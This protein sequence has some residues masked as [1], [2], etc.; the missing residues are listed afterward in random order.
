MENTLKLAEAK[1]NLNGRAEKS[2]WEH[3]TTK[4]REIYADDLAGK[5]HF[6]SASVFRTALSLAFLFFTSSLCF[7]QSK[8]CLLDVKE[9]PR[10]GGIQ[11]GMKKA[12]IEAALGTRLDGIESYEFLDLKKEENKFLLNENDSAAKK[13]ID[14]YKPKRSLS[15]EIRFLQVPTGAYSASFKP[16]AGQRN[17]E[18]FKDIEIISLSFFNDVSYSVTVDYGTNVYKDATDAQFYS[19]MSVLLG[20]PDV[21]FSKYGFAFCKNFV[22]SLVKGGSNT[23]PVRSN[24]MRINIFD[25]TSQAVI[26]E[27]AKQT[28]KETYEKLKKEQEP[29]K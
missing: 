11:L 20:M 23:L 14:I 21:T 8:P 9:S 13:V 28:V 18:K 27:K 29:K 10:L 1:I 7:P 24:E 25:S 4:A 3:L 6:L 17:T 5:K 26:R 19:S 22:I 12:E 16:N 15:N 2:V